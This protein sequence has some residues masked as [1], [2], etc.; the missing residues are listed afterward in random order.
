M[1]SPWKDCSVV[2]KSLLN[3]F[4]VLSVDQRKLLNLIVF[5]CQVVQGFLIKPNKCQLR[6]EFL[7]TLKMTGIFFVCRV[8]TNTGAYM[9]IFL[10]LSFFFCAEVS[11]STT[12]RTQ[13]HDLRPSLSQKETTLVFLQNGKVAKLPSMNESFAKDLEK[14]RQKKTWIRVTLNDQRHIIAFSSLPL[15]LPK[16]EENLESLTP[17]IREVYEPSLLPSMD[18]ARDFF[19]ETRLPREGETQ[20]FNRAHI[21]SYD[22]RT[23]KNLYSKKIWIFF[24]AKFIREHDFEW[25]FHVAPLIHVNVDGK[26]KERVMDMKYARGP[27]STKVW[28][29][30]FIKDDAPCPTVTNYTEHADFPESGSCY[31]QKSSMYYYQPIDL[32]LNEKYEIQK[33][34][35]IPS[36]LTQAFSE[37]FTIP[38]EEL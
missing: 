15:S 2:I 13:I 19:R 12:F 10:G 23:K 29:D 35:W 11:A 28:S 22:W 32:E 38:S 33:E 9:R 37:A 18:V 8:S 24:T 34:A 14:L 25:W 4:Y 1:T 36:E 3:L 27:I 26:I 5:F 16:E 30:I 17:T 6:E 20:C 21:W 31:L 7:A